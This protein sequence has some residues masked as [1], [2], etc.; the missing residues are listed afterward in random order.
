MG[1]IYGAAMVSGRRELVKIDPNW[2]IAAA[3]GLL[4]AFRIAGPAPADLLWAKNGRFSPHGHSV[5]AFGPPVA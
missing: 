5:L 3:D 4:T 2:L 1:E